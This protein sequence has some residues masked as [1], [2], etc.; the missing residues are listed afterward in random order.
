MAHVID[1][2][3]FSSVRAHLKEVLDATGR[4][5]T[6]TVARDG[7]VTAALSAERLR[8]Y[9]F[10]TVSPRVRV[11]AEGD[12]VVALMDDRP[13]AAEGTTIDDALTELIESLREYAEDWGDRLSDA[14]NHRDSWALVQLV[15]LSTDDQLRDWLDRGG[16]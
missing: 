5:R 12:A 2:P 10:R 15:V 4:G 6:V 8:E 14:P 13:F 16:E 11:F 7:V 1:Y 3:T 9:F